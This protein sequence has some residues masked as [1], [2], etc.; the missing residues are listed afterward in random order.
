MLAQ[1]DVFNDVQLHACAI[2]GWRQAYDQ[3]E[4]GAAHTVLRQLSGARV[5]VFHEAID[6]CVAQRGR[7]PHGRLCVAMSTSRSAMPLFQGQPVGAGRVT[8]LRADEEFF[9]QSDGGLALLALT[10]DAE[11]FAQAAGHALTDSQWQ[12]LARSWTLQVPE[13]Q[14]RCASSR[15]YRLLNEAPDE[16]Q[17]EQVATEVFLD[18][19]EHASEN[20][21][22][23][24]SYGVYAYLVR[25]SQECVLDALDAPPSI[26]EI[27]RALNVSRRTLQV[28][29]Q[30]V[31]GMRP[32]EYLRAVRL[33]EARRRLR[34]TCAQEYSV[35]QIAT[36]LGFGHLSHFAGNYRALFAEAPSQTP[37]R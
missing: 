10:L 31:T 27:C 22:R 21:L 4:S 26:L 18:L 9:V 1:T 28:S 30:E 19:L 29:F 17:A 37:R 15:L 16:Q 23:R 6:K 3:L 7:S 32:V 8:L 5:Q 12:H 14:L 25:K 34:L 13:P 33:N 20:T 35:A 36:D 24:S 2:P 11:H